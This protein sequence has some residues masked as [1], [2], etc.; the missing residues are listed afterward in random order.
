MTCLLNPMA[1]V[2]G[3]PWGWF[4]AG[5]MIGALLGRYLAGIL[6]IAALLFVRFKPKTPVPS[7][8]IWRHPDDKPRKRR[9]PF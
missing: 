2:A 6:V 5:V 1:C 4:L 9:R 3:L 8:E 7:E